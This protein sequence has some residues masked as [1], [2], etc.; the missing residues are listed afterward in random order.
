MDTEETIITVIENDDAE[1]IDLLLTNSFVTEDYDATE[2]RLAKSNSVH[3]CRA[4]EDVFRSRDELVEHMKNSYDCRTKKN[5]R[6]IQC[7][8]IFPNV[9]SF[10]LHLVS[11]FQE[12]AEKPNKKDE[13]EF[14]KY[15]CELC[16]KDFIS[17]QL[18]KKHIELH[19]E[20]RGSVLCPTCGK[21]ITSKEMYQRHRA[22]HG[23]MKT[24]QG[25]KKEFQCKICNE[26]LKGARRLRDHL[27]IHT[28]EQLFEC[29]VCKKTFSKKS[30]LRVHL[31]KTHFKS[32]KLSK[33]STSKKIIKIKKKNELK[34][35]KPRQ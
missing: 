3:A 18:K 11:H 24:K 29:S 7:Q 14:S 30:N 35:S 26:N 8:E 9:G 12:N 28:G 4:C 10:Q 27:R 34:A 16:G 5:Y 25:K 32:T 13:E 23:L 22:M 6:C 33:P 31:K 19:F 17:Q 1:D 21:C 2:E 20:Q 15:V